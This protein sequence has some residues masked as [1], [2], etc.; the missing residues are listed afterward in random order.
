[1]QSLGH[2]SSNIDQGR[3]RLLLVY[4]HG[5]MGNETSFQKLPAHVHNVVSAR[6]AASHTVHTKIYPRYK[7]RNHIGTATEAFSRWYARF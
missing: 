5:F 7:S 6:L 2:F 1:M 3:R 4:I